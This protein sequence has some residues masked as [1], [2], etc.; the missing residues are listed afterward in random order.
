MNVVITGASRGIGFATALAFCSGSENQV[1]AI[2]RSLKRLLEL[3]K[4]CA[5]KGGKIVPIKFDITSKEE[6]FKRK[7]LPEIA[8]RCQS[9]DILVNNA[10]FFINKKFEHLNEKEWKETLE[11]NLLG[12]VKLI[13][14]LLPLLEKAQHPHIINIGSM[15]GFQG[16][17]KFSGLAAYSASKSALNGLTECLAQEFKDTNRNISINC[18]CLGA[19]QTKMHAKAF[20]SNR[21]F[22]TA[23]EMGRFIAQFSLT[24]RIFN[25]KIIPVASTT[26]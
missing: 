11:T 10:G 15:G 5:A 7:L 25:G 16:S 3:K 22:I 8:S 6:E 24:G 4:I 19:V 9:I 13:K 23:E 1:F 20:P 12:H 18:L 21:A 2:S 26:P 17:V 14:V